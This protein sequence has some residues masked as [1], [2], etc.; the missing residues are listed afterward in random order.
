MSIFKCKMCGGDL[1]IAEGITV[2]EC[3]YCGTKQT[4]PKAMDENLQNLF[5]RA[6]TLRIK[7][8]FDKAERL[9]E[10]IVQAD[11]TQ[12]EAYW[13]LIL[14]KYGIEY[15]DDPATFKKVPTCHRASFDSI[16]ADDDYKSALEYADISQRA[17]Y[18]EQAR[19]I[20]RIQKEILALAQK[21][22][23]Y[24]VFLCYKETDA[25][26]QR[27]QDSVIANDIYYQLTQEGFKVFYAA[28]T[29][30]GKLGSAYEPIIF[31][32]LNSAKVMLA[33]GTK[34]EYFN[35]V[36][37]KN[38][39]SR[40]LKIIKKD[41]NKILIPCYRDMDAYELPEEFAHLQAQDMS[42]IGFIND[43]VRGIKKVINKEE[44]KSATI[45]KET[46]VTGSNAN[47]APLLKRAFIFLEDGDW[48]AANEYCEKVLDIEPE[49]AEAY[50]AKLMVELKVKQQDSLKDCAEPFDSMNNYQ[51]AVRFA[52]DKLK[53]TLSG[54][55][56][57][58]NV[59]NENERLESLYSS[60]HF[61]MASAKT[62]NEYKNAAIQFKEL[63]GYK[64]ADRLVEICVEKA[65]VARKDSQLIAAKNSMSVNTKASYK[66]AIN[67]LNSI[68]EWKN[69]AALIEECKNKIAEIEAKEEAKR[70][71]CERK[72]EIARKKAEE[73]AKRIKKIA[74]ITAPIVCAIIVFIIILNTVIIPN[75]KY[76][77]AIALMDA[78]KYSEAISAFETLAGYKDSTT[79]ISECKTTILDGK[80]N[81]AIALMDAGKYS[82]AISVFETLAG[83]KDSTT[84]ISECKTTIF[85][86]KYN[87]AIALMDAGKY[88]EAISAF[89]TL[90][91][92]KDSTTK[93]GECKT[94]ILD[95]KY[96]DAIALMDAGKYTEAI[97]AFEALE[98]YRD[99]INRIEDCN[100]NIYGEE[101]W[102]KI[103]N[104]NVGDTYK[105]GSYE[106]DNSKSNGQEAIE[107]LVLSK[108]G[109]KILVISKYALDCK[110][111]NTSSADV[112]WETCTLRNWLNNDFINAAFSANEKDMIHS[113][114]VSADKNPNYS[115]NPG[116]ATQDQVFLLS[117]IEAEKYFYS[118]SIRQC[119]PTDYAVARGVYANSDN[120]NCWWWL[121]SPG[122]YQ[123][124][125]AIVGNFG[126]IRE[127]GFVVLNSGNAVRPALWI[128]LN[129]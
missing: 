37:V 106:Q 30:E 3:E 44:P 92:Y 99:S 60:A 72:A 57:H 83:Y 4:V 71:E 88:S 80:Y 91:G 33:I 129:A 55:I 107:W 34:P 2:V 25:N 40:F 43:V 126:G 24:D 113:A 114:T 19:E 104:I 66:I 82:E 73:R 48:N 32:A 112:N 100:I 124:T 26:G 47:T 39:W 38:E 95:G 22:E 5:N 87:D 111:Y 49:C 46:V 79:K 118:E 21:E 75:G 6:N 116:N 12:S 108:E 85:D 18:E 127:R 115:T 11:S 42:K 16:V 101:V 120:G 27:T 94:T 122:E 29:L 123:N 14:C 53:A 77:D 105:F 50:V 17:L 31:A 7:S 110:Q 96:N 51:K 69:S 65:E 63:S 13:G 117:I 20:D 9:Y 58:I 121:R 23:S 68:P 54:Y 67:L 76:N 56:E 128:D 90:A 84:K 1:E 93:I 59:R 70:L 35:A 86:G 78:G 52:D 64:D 89:E 62:E 15:V 28:I 98:G 81:D 119:E 125:A 41:R 74:I 45:V 8:E 36:W 10:K 61:K 109:T 97:Y 103:K 102:N